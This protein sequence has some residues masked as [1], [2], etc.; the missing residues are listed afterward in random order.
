M[1][2][3]SVF[4]T[5]S[6]LIYFTTRWSLRFHLPI[7]KRPKITQEITKTYSNAKPRS[8]RQDYLSRR[9][10]NKGNLRHHKS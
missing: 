2:C 6:E 1:Q 9:N 8:W 10:I 3:I 5:I 7:D 4:L